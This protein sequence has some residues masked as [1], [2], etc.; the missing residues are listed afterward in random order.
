MLARG[1]QS[2][3]AS[4][5]FRCGDVCRARPAHP[6]VALD[7]CISCAQSKYSRGFSC[8][9][10]LIYGTVVVTSETVSLNP[11]LDTTS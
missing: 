3:G 9:R 4:E 10:D 6:G 1:A 11:F 2:F 5:M 8:S 7:P